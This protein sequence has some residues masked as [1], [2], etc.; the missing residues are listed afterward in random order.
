MLHRERDHNELQQLHK[1]KEENAKAEAEAA[2]SEDERG[3]S[4][5]KYDNQKEFLSKSGEFIIL[6]VR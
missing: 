6:S 3:H 1:E 5:K 4:R 2:T